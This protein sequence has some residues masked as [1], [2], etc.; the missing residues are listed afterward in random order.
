[1]IPHFDFTEALKLSVPDRYTRCLQ[2]AK[3][4]AL[5]YQKFCDYP[6]VPDAGA[7]NDE[8]A[9]LRSELDGATVPPEYDAFLRRC[10]Y[11]KID[12]GTEVGGFDHEGLYVTEVPWLSTQHRKGYRYLV[13]ANYWKYSDGDQ[14]MID[15]DDPSHPV[16]AYLHSHGPLFESYAPSFSLALWRLV[17]E[18][19]N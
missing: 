10:R 11:V 9:R 18:E 15:L 14:L 17:H 3:K 6:C 13:F 4:Q 1:M 5:G 7:S 8:I 19:E 2:I 12:D 16:I